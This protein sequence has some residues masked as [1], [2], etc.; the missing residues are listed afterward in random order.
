VR[1]LSCYTSTFFWNE[2]G[3]L[4]VLCL[5]LALDHDRWGCS[6]EEGAREGEREGGTQQTRT[7][8]LIKYEMKVIN[9]GPFTL[10]FTASL[11]HRGL[12]S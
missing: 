7:T 5:L 1:F 3:R 4:P 2:D 10:T 11:V 9:Y 8:D 12:A 6:R